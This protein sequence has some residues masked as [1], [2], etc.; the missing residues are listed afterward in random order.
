MRN[1]HPDCPICCCL[2]YAQEHSTAITQA[3]L[4]ETA[5]HPCRCPHGLHFMLLRHPH[6]APGCQGFQ[7]TDRLVPTERILHEELA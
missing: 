6:T 1:P 4:K 7:I 5:L 2:A 3:A